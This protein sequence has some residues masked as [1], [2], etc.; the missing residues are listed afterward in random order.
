MA[1]EINEDLVFQQRQW[2]VQRMGW[3]VLGGLLLLALLGVL[4]DGWLSQRRV[5]REGVRLEYDYFLREGKMTTLKL[6]GAGT[7]VSFNRDYLGRFEVERILPEPSESSATPDT[8]V[9]RFDEIGMVQF[10]LIPRQVGRV[11]GQVRVS[12]GGLELS[13]FVYP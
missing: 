2:R 12:G 5:V 6:E 11:S 7:E 4:G 8:V 1:L 10:N 9:F 13:H 3:F